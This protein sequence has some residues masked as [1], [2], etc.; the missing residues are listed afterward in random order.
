MNIGTEYEKSIYFKIFT[1]F[2]RKQVLITAN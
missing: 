2:V 1:N